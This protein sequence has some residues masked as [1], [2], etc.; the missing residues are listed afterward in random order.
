LFV[1][2]G[3]C[4]ETRDEDMRNITM[5]GRRKKKRYVQVI[6]VRRKVK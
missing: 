4:G 6:V 2:I 1:L 3:V 5:T